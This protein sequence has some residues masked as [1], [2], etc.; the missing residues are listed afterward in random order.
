MPTWSTTKLTRT[1]SPAARNVPDALPLQKLVEHPFEF[2][3]MIG[4]VLLREKDER[5]KSPQGLFRR[6][7]LHGSRL[8]GPIEDVDSHHKEF[9]ALVGLRVEL[10]HIRDVNLPGHHRP[11]DNHP[12]VTLRSRLKDLGGGLTSHELLHPLPGQFKAFPHCL[13]VDL[14]DARA[15]CFDPYLSQLSFQRLRRGC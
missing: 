4:I 5:P 13:V 1:V 6:L 14:L 3:S 15:A 10:L 12:S 7:G 2:L 11:G 8:H 9:E